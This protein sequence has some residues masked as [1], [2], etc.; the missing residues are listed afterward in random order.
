[1][2]ASHYLDA[3]RALPQ[4]DGADELQAKAAEMLARAGERAASL[5]RRGGGAPLLRAGV[6]ARRRAGASA[7][8]CSCAPAR[9]RGA[10]ADPE[11]ARAP[12]RGV[13][14]ALRAARATRMSAAR[15]VGLL[16]FALALHRPPRGGGRADGARVRG[17]LAGHRRTRTSPL[18]AARLGLNYWFLGDLERSAERARAGTR[19]RGGATATRS[20]SSLA[21]RAKGGG[22]VQPRPHRGGRRARRRALELA[23]EHDLSREAGT[24]YFILSDGEFRRDRYAAALGY[25][26]AALALA[27]KLGSRP[28]E[29][30]TLAEMTY[31]LCMLGRW[32]EALATLEEPT[33]EHTRSGGVLLSLL[34]SVARDPRR[35]AA[36]S[37]RHGGSSPCS[38]TS[39][40]RSTSRTAPRYL[41]ARGRL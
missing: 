39:R 5:A 33:E 20:H 38:A 7:P 3:Y 15:A 25:L 22:R 23:L 19:H 27:R 36:T 9:W 14:R 12:A 40:A 11:A 6:R 41:A 28:Y 24:S 31:P 18:L 4:E 10:P 35:S 21:L 37:T 8:R 32:D 26:R 16:G 30:A 1:M 2:I 29:W 34:Q 13:D 17:D